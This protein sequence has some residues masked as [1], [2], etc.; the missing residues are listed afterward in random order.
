MANKFNPEYI[1]K[2]CSDLTDEQL[3]SFSTLYS[4]NYGTWSGKDGK[5]KKG[6]PIKLGVKWYEGLRNQPNMYVSYCIDK[7]KLIGY[8]FFLNKQLKNGER[9]TWVTQLLVHRF[10]RN[11]KIGTKLLRSAWGFSNYLAWGLATTNAVTIKTLVAVTWR[12]V[13]P[14]VIKNHLGEIE[15]LCDEINFAKKENIRLGTN[16]SQIFTDFYPEFEKIDKNIENVYAAKLGSIEDGCEWLAFTF[17]EQS[18]TIFDEKRWNATL[19]FSAEQLEDAY[20][21]MEMQFQPWTRHT[22]Q[23]VDFIIEHTS[24]KKGNVILDMGCGQGRHSIELARRG[25]QVTGVDFSERLLKIAQNNAKEAGLDIRFLNRDCR[26]LSLRGTYDL[27]LCLYDVIGSYR[28]KEDNLNII[29][30]I[31]KK[32][33]PG[34]CCIVSV[35]NMEL[36]SY[37]AKNKADVMNNPKAILALKASDIMKKT[38]DI[39]DPDYF[40]LDEKAHLV[41]RKEQ[42]EFDGQLA[43][44]YVIADYRF[45]KDEICDAFESCGLSVKSASYVQ[46]GRWQTPLTSTDNKAKEILLIAQKSK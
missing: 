40:I 17:Q 37:I 28:T 2:R 34:G 18:Q 31:E 35:M 39:F 10:Y 21:R 7:E 33:R 23:E 6:E 32:L 24:L 14:D 30:S 44:E 36:T 5:H 25:F 8:A 12:K 16:L 22:S 11:R 13:T 45:T 29:R 1:T 42:F 26:N 19:D 9:C 27:I 41:Y 4:Q 3:Q 15:Q 46:A 38:G 43:S 20:S